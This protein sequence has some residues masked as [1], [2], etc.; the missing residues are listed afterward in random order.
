MLL[1]LLSHGERFFFRITDP[2]DALII[3]DADEQNAAIGVRESD[4]LTHNLLR[5][6]GF[7]LEFQVM[8]FT[9]RNQLPQCC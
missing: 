8:P 7:A 4:Q 6:R 2:W 1:Q 9:L 3:T 5:E